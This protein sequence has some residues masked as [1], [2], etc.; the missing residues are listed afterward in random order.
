MYGTGKGLSWLPSENFYKNKPWFQAG[1][2]APYRGNNGII[3]SSNSL[4][5]GNPNNPREVVYYNYKTRIQDL[6]LQGVVTLNNIRF[7]KSKTGFNFYMFAGAGALIYNTKVNAT[8]NGPAKYNF[9]TITAGTF[10]NRKDT[11]KALKDLLDDSY[12]SR[13]ERQDGR[14]GMLFQETFRYR[15]I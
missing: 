15:E 4:Q 3:V 6:S 12:D 9:S 1:Y 11:K 14:R 2:S 8:N 10:D 13:A 7:H 5:G